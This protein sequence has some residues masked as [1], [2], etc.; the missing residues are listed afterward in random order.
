MK[1]KS[2]IFIELFLSLLLS[3][4]S[5]ETKDIKQCD[6]LESFCKDFTKCICT[7]DTSMFFQLVDKKKLT[8]SINNWMNDKKK[9]ESN[10]LF[11]PFFFVYSPFIPNNDELLN[12]RYD[13]NFFIKFN[14]TKFSMINNCAKISIK[15]V[16]ILSEDEV[17]QINI[18][19]NKSDK[20]EVVDANW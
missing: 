8:V 14:I 10:D 18:T 7:K 20:W 2:L 6:N 9:I 4:N 19:V 11:F 1:I 15:W 16:Q 17:Q 12:A 5:F 13:S 3:C